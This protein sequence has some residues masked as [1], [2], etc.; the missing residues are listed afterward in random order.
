MAISALFSC[1][2]DPD[3]LRPADPGPV[4]E[5][6][7]LRAVA[8]MQAAADHAQSM[9]KFIADRPDADAQIEAYG[10]RLAMLLGE[11]GTAMAQFRLRRDCRGS[12]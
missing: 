2:I 4:H 11:A 1:G 12:A 6:H 8:A 5:A 10:D 3:S 7:R 9:V